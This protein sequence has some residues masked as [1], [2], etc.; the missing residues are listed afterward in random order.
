MKSLL[1]CLSAAALVAGCATPDAQTANEVTSERAYRTGSNIPK[2]DSNVRTLPPGDLEALRSR[3]TAN[4]GR[5]P[6]G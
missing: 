1:L 4:T 3:N 5:G 6:G 2:K